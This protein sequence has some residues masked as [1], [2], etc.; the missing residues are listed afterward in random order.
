MTPRAARAI[1]SSA[2]VDAQDAAYMRLALAEAVAAGDAGEVPIGAVLRMGDAVI[3]SGRNS[4]E[5]LRDASA[6]AEMLCLRAAASVAGDWRLNSRPSTLYVTVEPCPMCL[7]AIYAFR[8]E[9]LVYA[10]ENNR[11]GAVTGAMRIPTDHPFHTLNVD[12]GILRNEAAALM[13]D[14]FRR[15]RIQPSWIC[16][17][18]TSGAE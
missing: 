3:A 5:Q 14:F 7:A 13:H 2:T 9:R 6:H 16:E 15:R 8:V 12:S 18:T 10:T 4:V 17:K 1:C 11:L